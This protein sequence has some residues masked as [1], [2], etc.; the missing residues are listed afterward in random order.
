MLARLVAAAARRPG[1]VVAATL[2][3]TLV[4]GLLA[5]RLDVT[6]GTDTLVGGGTETRQ[7]TERYYERFGSDAIYVLVRDDLTDVMLTSDLGRLLGLEGCISGNA[8]AGQVP[9][10]GRE[11][12]CAKLA[13][14]KPVKAVFGPATF[15]NES[16][17]Q[18]T[19]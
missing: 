11:G 8:P 9:P 10:G 19:A 13:E 12:P 15:V 6:T 3:L 1:R 17:R 18:L 5:L 2:A 4:A 14:T 7:A 16:V